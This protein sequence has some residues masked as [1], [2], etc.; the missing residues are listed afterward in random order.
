MQ[1]QSLYKVIS[2]GELTDPPRDSVNRGLTLV[3]LPRSQS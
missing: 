1:R 3:R 2:N